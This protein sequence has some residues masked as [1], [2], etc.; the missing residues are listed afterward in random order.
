MAVLSEL[1]WDYVTDEDHN[2]RWSFRDLVVIS[3]L[4][5]GWFLEKSHHRFVPS[6]SS[7]SQV[8]L[9]MLITSL[10][11]PSCVPCFKCLSQS[12]NLLPFSHEWE[13]PGICEGTDSAGIFEVTSCSYGL[14]E[15]GFLVSFHSHTLCWALFALSLL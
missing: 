6:V 8:S 12:N 11:R 9:N 4:D 15:R 10:G 3:V 7:F 5:S 1:S 13:G 14:E 2:C